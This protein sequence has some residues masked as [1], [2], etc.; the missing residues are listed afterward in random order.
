MTT[1]KSG[2]L[3]WTLKTCTITAGLL[4]ML[5]H[6]D[7]AHAQRTTEQSPR[8]ST[9]PVNGSILSGAV[10]LADI[11]GDGIQDIIVG[12][13]DGKLHAYTGNGVKLWEYDTGDMG[14]VGK[15]A[16]GDLDSDGLMEIVVGAGDTFTPRAHG[17]LYVLDSRGRLRCSFA[18]MDTIRDGFRDG[19]YSSPALV[20][21]TGDGFLEIVFGSWDF[22]VRAIRH[23]CTVL[24]QNFVHDT[25]WSSPAIGDIDRDGFPDIVIGADAHTAPENGTT[26]GGMLHVF[27]RHGTRLP[28]F[29]KQIDEVIFSAP[30]LGD[31]NGDGWLDIVVGT[32]DFWGN[33]G[34]G[35][36]EGCTP[37]VGRYVNAWN[38]RGEPLP[39]W[40]QPT[41]A[42]VFASPALA[43]LDG[44]GVVDVIVNARD[45]T[46]HA[47]RGDG[48][49]ISGWPVKP[50]TPAGVGA[51]VSYHTDL[52]PLVA[53]IT[54]NGVREVLLPS[55]W[56]MVV[57][58][59]Q[60]SQITRSSFPPPAGTWDLSADYSITGNPALGDIDGDG[61]YDLVVGGATSD[62]QQGQIY[63]WRFTGA[64]QAD[65]W[66]MFRRDAHNHG[67]LSPL[68]IIAGL[69]DNIFLLHPVGS[70]RDSIET[71]LG[72]TVSGE[73]E[74]IAWNI[75]VTMPEHV[76]VDPVP[77]TMDPS[78]VNFNVRVSTSNLPVGVNDLGEVRISGYVNQQQVAG[79]PVVVS[80][81]VYVGNISFNFL[82]VI[83]Q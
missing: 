1:T 43:D 22:Y 83:N 76:D 17:G 82:P 11:T 13:R 62:G 41:N 35:H 66:K 7:A 72:V 53:D 32:G 77:D 47:W 61:L 4:L 65:D 54:G 57:W 42:V 56:E 69:T 39:G 14:I 12:G 68:P 21:L 37:G 67:R 79:S 48:S 16:I 24:W 70:D 58:N 38:H 49:A 5:S 20:D 26:R 28:G 78:R 10:A 74:R 52:S 9:I 46:V 29:P 2:W 59:N 44:N 8:R 73:N 45:A 40:P 71:V 25:V 55:N 75:E 50:V 63:I 30:A 31:I 81:S 19:V 60:G 15:A 64:P 3:L 80:V 33:P 27:D 34:C 51:T 18:T 23:D 36:P 6:T